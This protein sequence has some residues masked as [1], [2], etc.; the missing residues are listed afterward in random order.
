LRLS[1][2]FVNSKRPVSTG[3]LL[4]FSGFLGFLT[5]LG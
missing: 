5:N 3:F 4:F 2:S 1:K